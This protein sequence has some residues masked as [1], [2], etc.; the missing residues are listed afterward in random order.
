MFFAFYF[1]FTNFGT[2]TSGR[3]A[4]FRRFNVH[5]RMVQFDIWSEQ[6]AHGLDQAR[7]DKSPASG[8]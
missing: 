4:R 3:V 7:V 2:V 6:I 5:C 8:F 1:P